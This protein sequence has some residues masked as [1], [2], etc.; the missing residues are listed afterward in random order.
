MTTPPPGWY[1][2]GDNP[3]VQRWWTGES[4]TSATQPAPA[5]PAPAAPTAPTPSAPQ[6]TP[7]KTGCGGCL[8]VLLILVALV[9][10][11]TWF[12]TQ[13]ANREKAAT[14]GLDDGEAI[15]HCQ[16]A[17]K[18]QLRSPSTADFPFLEAS[19]AYIDGDWIAQG[20]VDSQNGFGATV[21]S[22]YQCT[23]KDGK[24]ITVDFIVSR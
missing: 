3:G 16:A 4:W 13:A 21:R 9:G 18:K 23:I 6:P 12:S 19:A 8:I 15:V 11:G 2:D 7:K 20:V 17:V 5:A 14:D 24:L 1:P 22:D 10:V